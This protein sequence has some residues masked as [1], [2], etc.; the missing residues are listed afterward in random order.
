M[1]RLL[2][3]Q[4]RI[5]SRDAQLLEADGRLEMPEK[6]HTINAGKHEVWEVVELEDGRNVEIRSAEKPEESVRIARSALGVLIGILDRIA[7]N[8]S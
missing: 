8:R 6:T 5:P 3:C 2:G 1:S 7:S 4:A